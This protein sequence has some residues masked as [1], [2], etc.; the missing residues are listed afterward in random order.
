MA[1]LYSGCKI[2]VA[3]PTSGF[4]EARVRKTLA[5]EY[6]GIEIEFERSGTSEFLELSSVFVPENHFIDGSSEQDPATGEWKKIGGQTLFM[7]AG[8][9]LARLNQE[10]LER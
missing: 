8:G 9:V 7:S 5:D 1:L 3:I 6:P 10:K 4:D 2:T